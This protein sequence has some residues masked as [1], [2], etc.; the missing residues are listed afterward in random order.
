[1]AILCAEHDRSSGDSFG[2]GK[3]ELRWRADQHIDVVYT[4]AT[5][6]ERVDE[7]TRGGESLVHLPVAGDE[8][9][10][11]HAKLRVWL[12]TIP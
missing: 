8:R 12:N 2:H 3:E 1:M 4:F 5:G 10:S 6:A 7:F 9:C 11:T